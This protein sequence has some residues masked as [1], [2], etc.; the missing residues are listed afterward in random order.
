MTDRQRQILGLFSEDKTLT[1]ERLCDKIGMSDFT[2]KREISYLK[3]MEM[4]ERI[5][6][7]KTGYWIIKG[8]TK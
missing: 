4:L 2:A 6:S 1:S 8:V 3:K 5:G 7:D